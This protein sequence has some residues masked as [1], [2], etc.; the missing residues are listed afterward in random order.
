MKGFLQDSLN[1]RVVVWFSCGAASACAAKLAVMT[2]ANVKVVY[3]NTLASEHPDNMRFLH[4][5]EKWINRPIEIISSTKFATINDVFEN[6]NYMSGIRGAPCTLEMKKVPRFEYEA[7]NDL[8]IFGLTADEK[9][10]ILLFEQNNPDLILEWN[11]LDAGI[12]KQECYEYLKEDGI[13]L[14][15]MYSLGFKNN[16]CIA[17]VKATSAV[18]WYNINRHFPDV[19]AKRAFQSRALGCRLVRYKGERMFLDQLPV[20]NED[21]TPEEDIECGPVCVKGENGVA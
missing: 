16:N 13:A 12:T 17:C 5:V 11:L 18:Y 21:R 20:L 1:G 19:F 9:R 6:R 4:D 2:H 15:V 14:P 8:H 7:P 10:R 3:C